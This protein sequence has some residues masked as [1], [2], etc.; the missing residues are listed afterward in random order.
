MELWKIEVGETSD[1][2]EKS[3]VPHPTLPKEG[4][5]IFY[6]EKHVKRINYESE[7]KIIVFITA[8]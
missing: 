8:N 7:T 5:Y 1:G 3:Y 6:W 2:N 4:K